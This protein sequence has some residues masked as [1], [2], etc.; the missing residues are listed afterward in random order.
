MD[1]IDGW[2]VNCNNAALF[3]GRSY[4]N[5]WHGLAQE[6]PSE[7][8][9]SYDLLCLLDV[10]EHLDP[11]TAK[12]LLRT[13]LSSMGENARL[14]ISTPLCFMPQENIHAGDL[15]E[16]LIGVPVTSMIALLP[17]M[18]SIGNSL[19]GGF[20]LS[21]RSLE[22]IE[23]FQP[24]TDKRFNHE[25]GQRLLRAINMPHQEGVLYKCGA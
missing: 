5:V 10:I 22:N 21:K 2:E 3:A 25:R 12:W 1:G 11:E 24:T 6:L 7:L 18:Y 20:V 19:V 8:I 15:E 13:L 16:H 17:L 14:F 4:R 9:A 23:F